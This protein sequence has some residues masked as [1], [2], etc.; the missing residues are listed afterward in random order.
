MEKPYMK[1]EKI[2]KTADALVEN[3][4]LVIYGK[5]QKIR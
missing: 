1:S 3:V 4:G 5:E 2:K